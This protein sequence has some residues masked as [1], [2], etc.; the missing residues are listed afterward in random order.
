MKVG[1][2][3]VMYGL[4]WSQYN[5]DEATAQRRVK[6]LGGTLSDMLKGALSFGLGIGLLQ[7][8]QS[9]GSIITNF[10]KS[11]VD[12]ESSVLRVNDLFA[13]ASKYITFFAENTAKSFGMAE[14]DA[15]QYAAVYGNLFRNI[16]KNAEENAKLTIAM[17]KAS[18]IVASKTGR[19][20]EDTMERIRSGLLGN[21]EAIEDLGIYVNVAML[22]M[23][24]AFKRIANGRSWDKLNF[25]EQQQIR[26]LAI[27]EQAHKNFGDSVTRSSA[28]LSQ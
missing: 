9:T 23:T 25:Y 18:A 20:M 16:T 15:Y 8:L 28:F 24:D 13:N 1:E 27:L 21:T 4:D 3:F 17:L 5:K 19:T 11:F 12:Q 14:A 7:G 26:A 6:K 2:L 10:F 22:E